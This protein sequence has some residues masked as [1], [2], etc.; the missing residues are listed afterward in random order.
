MF[1]QKKGNYTN[2]TKVDMTSGKK[3]TTIT[4]SEKVKPTSL[5]DDRSKSIVAQCLTKLFMEIRE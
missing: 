2:I 4:E 1:I 5:V 3:N